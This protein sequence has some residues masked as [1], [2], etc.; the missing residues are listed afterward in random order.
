MRRRKYSKKKQG[1]KKRTKP[2][3]LTQS[4]LS[5]SVDGLLHRLKKTGS[6]SADLPSSEALERYAVIP[7]L[8]AQKSTPADRQGH[9]SFDSWADRP[10]IELRNITRGH[11]RRIRLQAGPISLVL[12][13][14]RRQE[15]WSFVARVY[16]HENVSC[17]FV[18]TAGGHKLLPRTQGFYQWTSARTPRKLGLISP[19]MKVEFER[20]K[21]L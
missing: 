15:D 10:A 21:W 12:V 9:I 6:L 11:V 14:E 5:M 4:T 3:D 7:L 20:L 18:I 17:E 1:S 19:N 16:R 2:Q 13:A 8:F